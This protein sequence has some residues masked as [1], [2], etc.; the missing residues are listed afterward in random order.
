MRL[1][2]SFYAVS[3]QRC[4]LIDKP[5][6]QVIQFKQ[7]LGSTRIWVGRA[8]HVQNDGHGPRRLVSVEVDEHV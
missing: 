2:T 5:D 6:T 4:V 7:R 3:V 1:E 8:C